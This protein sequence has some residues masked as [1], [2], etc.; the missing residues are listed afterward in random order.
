MYSQKN[1]RIKILERLTQSLAGFV[2]YCFD[3][4]FVC[5][6]RHGPAWIIQDKKKTYQ[7]L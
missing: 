1:A 3:G 5:C 2:T 6:L 4:D 7:Y